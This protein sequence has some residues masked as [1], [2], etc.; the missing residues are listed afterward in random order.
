MGVSIDARK[1]IT[2]APET[3]EDVITALAFSE[4]YQMMGVVGGIV[5]AIQVENE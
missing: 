2:N 4:E 5:E 1:I 3:L